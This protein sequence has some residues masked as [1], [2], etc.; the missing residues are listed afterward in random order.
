[1]QSYDH[2]EYFW[3][4]FS[5]LSH[6]CGS[7][8][9]YRQKVRLGRNNYSLE[10]STRSLPFLTKLALIFYIDRKKIVPKDIYNMLTPVALALVPAIHV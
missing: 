1:M 9:V 2:S 5:S 6:Y 10:F 4:V 3:F 8:P 7:Y